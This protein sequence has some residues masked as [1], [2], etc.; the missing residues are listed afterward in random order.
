MQ[1]AARALNRSL[2]VRA[3]S[4]PMPW[5]P[6]RCAELVLDGVVVGYA[7]ELHPRACENA[8]LPARS[9]AAEIDLDALIAAAT[10]VVSAPSVGTQPLAKEDLALVVDISVPASEV[11]D[12]LRAGAGDLVESVR[13]F[14]VYEGPQVGEGKRSLAFTLRLRAPDRT[15]SAEELAAAREGALSEAT[16]RVGAVLR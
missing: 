13:L 10:R 3:G 7:G 14:D 5:H 9:A 4:A 6:G 12:A 11:A 15:L 2:E 8:G 1:S 16:R